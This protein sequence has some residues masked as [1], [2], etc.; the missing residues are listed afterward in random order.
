GDWLRL[1]LVW[2]YQS[3][4]YRNKK[5]ILDNY[6]AEELIE[7]LK[8]PKIIHFVGADKPWN[9]ICYHP[10]EGSYVGYADAADVKLVKLSNLEKAI[11]SFTSFKKIKKY[12]RSIY[13]KAQLRN[14]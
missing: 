3:G 12:I 2:N 7:V 9:K 11:F 5:Y 8:N 10:W 13:R 1:P 6:G 14:S 4:I